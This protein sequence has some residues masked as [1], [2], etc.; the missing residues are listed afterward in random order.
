VL[1]DSPSLGYVV[2]T[3]QTGI[4]HGPTVLTYYYPFCDADVQRARARLLALDWKECVD[5]VFADLRRA[6]PDIR[7]KTTRLDVMRWGHA[8]VRPRPGFL[9]GGARREAAKPFRGIHCAAADL[10]GVGLFEEA[11]DHGVRAAEEVLAVRAR[12]EASFR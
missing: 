11:F 5:L 4:D 8:M 6:H 2:A 7:E 12:L 1:Y 10:S 9:W 3:H